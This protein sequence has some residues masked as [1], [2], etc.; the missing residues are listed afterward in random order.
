MF[1]YSLEMLF[2]CK[3]CSILRVAC[4]FFRILIN[5]FQEMC[6]VFF[7]LTIITKFSLKF[8]LVM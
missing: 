1:M 4:T 2:I 6:L 5:T 7:F 8:P 3:A